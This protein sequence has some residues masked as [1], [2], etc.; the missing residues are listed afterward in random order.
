[1]WDQ[2]IG[3]ILEGSPWALVIVL[4]AS[5]Y[6]LRKSARADIKELVAEKDALYGKI[7]RLLEKHQEKVEGLQ[8]KRMQ[9]ALECSQAYQEALANA[10]GSMNSLKEVIKAQRGAV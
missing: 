9:E 3:P 4:G 2:L 10:T 7:E 8:E 6:Y 1:M 5:I